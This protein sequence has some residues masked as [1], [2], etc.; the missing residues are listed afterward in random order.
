M[1]DHST[2]VMRFKNNVTAT[3]FTGCYCQGVRPDCGLLIALNDMVIDYRLRKNL[4]M[5]S[6]HQTL[7]ID[8][9]VDQNL[10]LA[11]AFVDAV[12]TGNP[13]GIRSPYGDAL[14]TLKL[15]FAANESMESGKVIYFE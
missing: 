3:L 14:K 1:D 4:I 15:T 2:T 13:A 5:R 8:C 12:R 9:Q 10:L 7:N 6:A 11:R